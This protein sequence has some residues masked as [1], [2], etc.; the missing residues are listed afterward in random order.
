VEIDGVGRVQNTRLSV[1]NGLSLLF[2]AV[3]NS[4][5]A[6]EEAE[7]TKGHIDIEILRDSQTDLRGEL[8]ERTLPDI[9]GFSVG[10]AAHS[11]SGY[12]ASE[13]RTKM[14]L[15]AA[16]SGDAPLFCCPAS[17]VSTKTPRRNLP[18]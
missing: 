8:G 5:Y 3:V 11:T 6:I 9:E 15:R 10:I 7:A 13:W 1:S 14:S 17:R 4:I 16:N 2:E 18:K 12:R